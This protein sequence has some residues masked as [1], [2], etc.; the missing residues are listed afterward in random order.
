MQFT[1]MSVPICQLSGNNLARSKRSE[2]HTQRLFESVKQ[3]GVLTP[4]LVHKQTDKF[5]LIAGFGRVAASTAAGNKEIPAHVFEGKA[6]V[7]QLISMACQENNVRE[8]MSLLDQMDALERIVKEDKITDTEAG[9]RIGLKQSVTSKILSAKARLDEEVLLALSQ[10]GYGYS[11]AYPLS[12]AT[13]EDQ[14]RLCALLIKENWTRQK[15]EDELKPETKRSFR[16]D[17][18]VDVT[19][20]VPKTVTYEAIRERLVEVLKEIKRREKQEIPLEVLS[21][22][23]R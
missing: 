11:F 9:K 17:G 2:E 23:M 5:V 19:L 12:K 21:K 4:I 14:K 7:S 8:N 18:E 16:F 3:F 15:L 1:L 6:T 10:N 20:N 13:P 22:V